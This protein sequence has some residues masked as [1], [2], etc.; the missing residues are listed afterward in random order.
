MKVLVLG[1]TSFVGR[2]MVEKLLGN[3]HEVV[4]FNRGKSNPTVFP[5][6]RRILG[7]R[8]KDA[9]KLAGEK[10][11]AVIDT[12]AY[13]PADLKPILE[14]ITTDHYTFVSTVSV[15]T[16]FSKGPVVENSSVFRQT[17]TDDK[18]T[19]DTYGPLK[20]MC[21]RFI[22]ESLG[23]A[24]LIIRP[25]IVIG[26]FDPT[27]RF[28]YWA[29]KLS[30][31]ETVLVPGSKKRQVQWI[32][33]RDLAEFT[34]SQ[35]EKKG[36]G[37]FNVVADSTSMEN[38]I[39]QVTSEKPK[40]YWVHDHY[41]LENKLE[42]FELPFWIPISADFPEGFILVDNKKAKR[43]GLV[44]RT[45]QQ[46]TNDVLDWSGKKEVSSLKAGIS[47]EKERELLLGTEIGMLD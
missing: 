29:I 20:M 13:T 6:L 7:D 24:A 25:G 37:V 45:L 34:V 3:G 28:T 16:D 42:A 36:T 22:E 23:D 47:K 4:L 21:E 14:N 2:H 44:L 38:F 11:E 10:W 39:T 30:S 32:D 15:Y 33:A 19:G 1:G 40:L 31:E 46:S 43:A 17:I 12:S 35:M 18:V 27:D 26:P 9:T 41:L 5:E 8:R